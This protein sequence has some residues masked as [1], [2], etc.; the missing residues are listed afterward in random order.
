MFQTTHYLAWPGQFIEVGKRE[1][2]IALVRRAGLCVGR[3][4]EGVIWEGRLL[5]V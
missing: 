2:L 3:R 1:K 4:T 5:G